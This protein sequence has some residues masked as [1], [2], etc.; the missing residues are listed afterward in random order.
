MDK[1]FAVFVDGDNIC[2]KDY[3][4]ALREIVST[5]GIYIR[6]YGRR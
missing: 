6:V 4:H 3:E 2:A 5:L 1:K